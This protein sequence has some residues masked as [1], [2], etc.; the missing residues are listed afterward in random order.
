MNAYDNTLYFR[1]KQIHKP[2]GVLP[3]SRSKFYAMVNAGEFPAGTRWSEGVVVWERQ[4]VLDWAQKNQW[5]GDAGIPDLRDRSAR[6]RLGTAV[7][8][9]GAAKRWEML[10]REW[11]AGGETLPKFADRRCEEGPQPFTYP[12]VNGS[13]GYSHETIIKQLGRLLRERRGPLP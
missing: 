2:H 11:Q 7:N 6:A 12:T 13:K 3:I 1:A 9:R 5:L 4:V 10:F 8:S